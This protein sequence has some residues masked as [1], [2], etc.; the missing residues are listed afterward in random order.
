[1][2]QCLV[3]IRV[4]QDGGPPPRVG[5]VSGGC[6]SS[7]GWRTHMTRRFTVRSMA[8]LCGATLAVSLTV[9]A[10]AQEEGWGG[11][12]AA[13]ELER[14]AATEGDAERAEAEDSD[15]GDEAT[16][17]E[18][19]ELSAPPADPTLD[20]DPE[21]GARAGSGR[22][23][24]LRYRGLYIPQTVLGWFIEGGQSVYIHGFGP[25]LSIRDDDVEYIFA[26][27]LSFYDMSPVAIKGSSD[28]EEA[29][30]IVESDMKAV[31]LTADYLWHAPLARALELSY[32]AGAGLGFLFGDL[33]RTQ[34]TLRPGGT[35]GNPDDFIPCPA[36]ND[37]DPYCDDINDHY[38]D[39]TE[40]SWFGGGAKPVVFPW[41]S[42]QVGLRYQP[43]DKVVTRLD[44]GLS[45]TGLF[46][47]V[48]A[49]YSL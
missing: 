3:P 16:A 15:P 6:I 24:G 38:G 23:L 11:E 4:A 8:S 29:W 28:A 12:E 17:A 27:W 30:E 5:T 43:H 21:D 13:E 33:Y 32:G 48:G 34:A 7:I 18:P 35:P 26:A 20:A 10:G 14:P 39:Y 41:L 1:M 2:A 47:G 45:T 37:N 22:A 42:A 9:N 31:Y 49:D 46:F 36:Q 44:L 19:A 40:P 25:E